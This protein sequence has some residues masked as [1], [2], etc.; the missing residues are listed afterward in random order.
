MP[1]KPGFG[2]KKFSIEHFYH[3]MK[4][5]APG[6]KVLKD[7]VTLLLCSNASGDCRTKPMLIYR[8]LNLR[9]LKGIIENALPVYWK[10]NLG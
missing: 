5:T 10:A 2:G 4:K 8:S 3:K 7:L 1:L 6:F 9:V